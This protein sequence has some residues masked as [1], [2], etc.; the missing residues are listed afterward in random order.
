V[1]S[2]RYCYNEEEWRS[3]R[4]DP[5]WSRQESDYLMDLCDLYD[6]RWVVIADRYEVGSAARVKCVV[7]PRPQEFV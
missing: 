3:L 1:Q 7:T 4:T 2:Q 6:M 5:D